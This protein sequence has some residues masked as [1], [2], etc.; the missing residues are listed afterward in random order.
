[1]T[2]CTPNNIVFILL[3]VVFCHFNH[4]VY[5]P[6][7]LKEEFENGGFCSETDVSNVFR[8]LCA[9]LFGLVCEEN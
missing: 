6:V 4:T 8:L 7:N 5:L 3:V 1:M 2:R 9:S